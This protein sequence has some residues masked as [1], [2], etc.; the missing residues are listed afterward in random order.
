MFKTFARFIAPPGMPSPVLWGDERTVDGTLWRWGLTHPD[1][2]GQLSDSTTPRARSTSWSSSVRTTG[3]PPARSRRLATRINRRSARIWCSSG[4]LTT[5]RP[6]LIGRWSIWS[7]WRSSASARDG[8]HDRTQR[9]PCIAREP[10]LDHGEVLQHLVHG[11]IVPYPG[12]SPRSESGGYIRVSALGSQRNVTDLDRSRCASLSFVV[13]AGAEPL[14]SIPNPR[15][16]DGS[17]VT[18]VP[19]NLR[20]DTV[21][22]LNSTIGDL[23]RT[24]G[25]EM[26]VV[27]IGSLDGLSVEEAAVRLFDLWGIGRKGRTTGCC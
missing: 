13:A 27:V 3:R 6:I 1:D 14:T 11:P 21:A 19:A 18:D 2:P 16:R 20:A 7:I 22:R 5:R 8:L 24:T 10:S 17:W 26:A 9:Q 12:A 25:G 15:T 4:H 23:E